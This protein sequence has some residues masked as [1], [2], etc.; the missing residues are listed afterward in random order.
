MASKHREE[1]AIADVACPVCHAKPGQPCREEFWLHGKIV[2]NI[3]APG[4]PHCHTARRRAWVE[5][6][7]QANIRPA[8]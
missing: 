3:F 4:R 7:Q 5:M 1:K 2:R 6:K 8:D